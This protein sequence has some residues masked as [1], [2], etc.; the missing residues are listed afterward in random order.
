[1]KSK[2]EIEAEMSNAMTKFEIEYMGRGPK[3]AKSFL[4]GDMILVRLK[5]V[6][7]PAEERLAESEADGTGRKLIKQMRMQ[8]LEQGRDLVERIAEDITGA[9]VVSLHTDLST[10]TGER[11][12]LFT[13]DRDV[14]HGHK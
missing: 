13:F 12:I 3:E 4:L 8:L 6:L 9:K 5:G 1:M 14:P 10:R 2:G 7:T 11:M